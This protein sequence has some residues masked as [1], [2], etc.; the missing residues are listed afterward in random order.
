MVVSNREK[1]VAAYPVIVEFIDYA[2]PDRVRLYFD[3]DGEDTEFLYDAVR[4]IIV[5]QEDNGVS[6]A[7]KYRRFEVLY[8]DDTFEVRFTDKTL[9]YSSDLPDHIPTWSSQGRDVNKIPS[10]I[11]KQTI[12][13]G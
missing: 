7:E 10:V 9:A 2:T 4:R 1:I 5:K 6:R 11:W 3:D 13:R 12:K 8:E